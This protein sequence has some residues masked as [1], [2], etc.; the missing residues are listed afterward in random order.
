MSLHDTA[1]HSPAHHA[2]QMPVGGFIIDAQGRE[3]A[4]TEEM[5]Q[6]AC[7]LLEQSRQTASLQN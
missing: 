5:I 6:A 1:Q 7:E 3:V 2:R 4:I